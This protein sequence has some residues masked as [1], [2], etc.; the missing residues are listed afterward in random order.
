MKT[1]EG[2]LNSFEVISEPILKEITFKEIPIGRC[3]KNVGDTMIKKSNQ[4]A[5]VY[6]EPKLWYWFTNNEKCQ[7]FTPVYLIR[8][9]NRLQFI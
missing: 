4:T 6:G 2:S 7:L 5:Y 3:F 8:N 9:K 1:Y